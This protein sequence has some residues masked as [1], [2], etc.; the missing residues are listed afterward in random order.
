MTSSNRESTPLE[1]RYIPLQEATKLLYKDNAKQHDIGG[2]V[3]SFGKY[4][5]RD[6]CAYDAKLDAIVEGNGRIE[7]LTFMRRQG[8]TPPNGIPHD[9]QDWYVPVLFGMDSN[10]KAV[11]ERYVIDHNNLTM[12][13]GDFTA[14]DMMRM[15][16]REKYIQQ[17]ELF[18]SEGDMPITVDFDTL[19]SLL[20][21]DGT[22][23]DTDGEL[24]AGFDVPVNSNREEAVVRIIVNNFNLISDV[25]EA[26]ELYL[27]NYPE[28]DAYVE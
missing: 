18:S 22:E 13:G 24:N 15:W 1:L 21:S 26:L 20:H 5:F 23:Y 28:W 14:Y 19:E 6:P 7:A 10:S 11:A 2:I 8:Q 27:D 9:S 16:D 4:G 12:A 3:Q 25:R 17:L